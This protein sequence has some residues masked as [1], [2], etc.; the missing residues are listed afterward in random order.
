MRNLLALTLFCFSL[1][2]KAQF[3]TVKQDKPGQG[4]Q[5]EHMAA[6]LE[7]DRIDAREVLARA[8]S[9]HLFPAHQ[10]Y[11]VRVEKDVPIFVS[12]TDSLMLGLLTQ[13]MDVCLPLDFL[14][15]TSDFGMRSDPFTHCRRFHD[16]IDL[17]CNHDRVY[18]M[19]PAVVKEVHLGKKG[20]GNYVV[21]DHGSFCCL[22]GHLSSVTVAPGQ[23][24]PAG[25]I[26]GISG[27]SGRS[28]GPHLHIQM[29][30]QGKRVN[31][32]PFL[33]YLNR[34]ISEL[35]N[36]MAYIKYGKRPGMELNLTNLSSVLEQFGVK[37]PKIVMAQSLLESGYFTS[38]VCLE[39]NNLFGLRRPSDGSYYR[40]EKW[41]DSVKAYRDYV[42]Y[43]YRGG[44]YL[45]FLQNIGYAE[46]PG[47]TSQVK[48]I[49]ECL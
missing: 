21:L 19:L 47:Y 34:Y 20:Y 6:M 14:K 24:I 32:E 40:F 3:F 45:D 7:D 16:G 9:I 22:Y 13:R 10:G 4:T 23:A 49:A 38:H 28:T 48:R 11:T 42:Q 44:N 1:G 12:A 35:Q 31:P 43:K 25:T 46:A 27:N 33:A 17:Q 41:E 30:R 15:M 18:A 26:V 2:I 36:K 5:D 8:D 29:T 37:F 39:Y